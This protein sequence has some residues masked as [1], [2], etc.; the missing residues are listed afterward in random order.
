MT[1]APGKSMNE[2]LAAAARASALHAPIAATIPCHDRPAGRAAWGI[3]HIVH[4]LHG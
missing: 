1:A 4:A 3:A 2:L